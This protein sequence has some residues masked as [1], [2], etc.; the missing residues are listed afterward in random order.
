MKKHK[1]LKELLKDYE[2]EKCR[3]YNYPLQID[4]DDL[5]LIEWYCNNNSI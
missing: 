4:Q 1:N 2:L 3:M 5:Q